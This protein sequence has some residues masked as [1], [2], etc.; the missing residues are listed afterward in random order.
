[1][2]ARRRM[3]RASVGAHLIV[4]FGACLLAL[5]VLMAMTTSASFQRERER[6]AAQLHTA[7]Q[8][9]VRWA[10]ETMPGAL[11]VLES[12]SMQPGI[13]E[14]DPT[15]CRDV[16][17]G[18]ASIQAQ[19]HLHL[20]RSDGS[21]VCSLQAPELPVEE[22]PK[23][24]WFQRVID[25]GEPVNGGTAVDLLS[26][27]P[28]VVVAVPVEG[29]DGQVG[30]L[31]AVL[32][33]GSAPLE[34]PTGA[35]PQMVLIELNAER[36]LVLGT[37]AGAPVRTGPIVDSWLTKP[38][39]HGAQTVVDTDGVTRIYEELEAAE[40]GWVILAGLPRSVAVA[41]AEQELRRNLWLAGAVLLV[42]AGL[43]FI[44]HR[45]LARPV[46]K[47]RTAIEAARNDDGARAPVE[48]P[49]EIA[50]VAEAFNET[51]TRRRELEVQLAHQALHDPLT[52]LPNRTL[53][54]DRLNQALARQRRGGHAVVVAF[55]D[56]D[57]F[58][59]INDSKG[60]PVGDALLVSLARRLE[61][62]M[63][64]EDTV[65]RFGGDE[66]VVVS[67]GVGDDGDVAA[68]AHRLKAA[69]DEPFM[70]STESLRISGSIGLAVSRNEETADELIR[71][72]DAAMYA[73]KEKE[74]G[75]FAIYQE[76]LHAGVVSR[77]QIERDLDRA[78][79]RGEFLLHYQPKFSLR[80]GEA[81]GVEALIRWAHPTKGLVS[82][83]DFIPVCEETGLI[84]PLGQ[85]VLFEAGRQARLWKDRHDLSVAVSVNLS[86]RQLIRPDLTRLVATMLET[87]G[88][89][90]ADLC[91]EI[92][93]GTLLQDM[94]AAVKH[95][96]ELR[97]L[98]VRISID[99]FGTG[100]SSLAYLRTLP[101]DELKIDR[102]FVTP[103]ADDASA[104]AIVESVVR[105][106]HAL[107]LLV[108]AEGVETADQLST[109]RD[110]G[111]DLAQ[112]FYLARPA[113]APTALPILRRPALDVRPSPDIRLTKDQL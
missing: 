83:A 29:S 51:I 49:A 31:A 1:M 87:T 39:P 102:S 77:L 47:L 94:N 70:L 111:C 44:L 71:N 13:T 22:I 85:W 84:V 96:R 42:V 11:E 66:F 36:N 109:L 17:S 7:V 57:R 21:L 19:G 26:G 93:E 9:N 35:S 72:A 103:V 110:L 40:I 28:A 59:L 14:F 100:Y 107:G 3:P 80:T 15:V 61:A 92:T 104:A 52:G 79:D 64:S 43:G 86:A 63:R 91:L 56:L 10:D 6:A 105:L 48:G 78:L 75:G 60:H 37:S 99:D 65:A 74:R 58:K 25:T 2:S 23:G 69:L 112:G 53:L 89:D 76:P 16:F 68:I 32:Y 38:L 113:A 45:R 67:E 81:V 20:F 95:L 12:V 101:L 33:T 108:V 30:V 98:G 5:G 88:A 54:S 73:A 4:A 34:L 82:P 8:E 90:P 41:A 106:G 18:L 27:H 97:S 24:D 62:A 55:M 50:E 46:R